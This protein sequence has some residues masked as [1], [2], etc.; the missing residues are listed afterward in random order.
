MTP[1]KEDAQTSEA[2]EIERAK[3]EDAEG[4]ILAL[5][6]ALAR[7]ERDNRL[8]SIASENAER[9]RRFHEAE[10]T[11]VKEQAE[12]AALSKSNFLAN[13]SHEI[14]TPMNAIKGLSELLMLTDLNGSQRNYVSNII[15]SSNSLLKI[16]NDVLDFSKI[17]AGRMEI[18]ESPYELTSLFT[19]LMSTMN[20][21]CREKELTLIA[22]VDPG[23][24]R[25]LKGDDVRVKQVLSN[26][27]SNAVKYTRKGCIILSLR[28]EREADGRDIR[29]VFSVRDTGIGIRP[30]DMDELFEAFS[31]ADLRKNRTII[32]TGLGLAI[33]KRLVQA[34][35]GDISLQSVYGEGS[36]FSFW[37][38][39]EVLDDTP[40]AQVR[41][42]R[43]LKVLVLG[44]G[45]RGDY[46]M[47]M[48]A[49]LSVPAV[50]CQDE[51][52]LEGALAGGITHCVYHE[53]EP[54][55]TALRNMRKTPENFRLVAVRDIR[56]VVEEGRGER[57]LVVFEPMLVTDLARA[58]DREANAGTGVTETEAARVRT[59][60]V[61]ALLVDDNE[62][63]LMVGAEILS[64]YGIETDSAASGMEAL[65]DS[66]RTKYDIIFMDQMMPEMDGIETTQKIRGQDGPNL[67]TPIVALTA[68]VM[69]DMRDVLIDSGMDDF[70]GKPIEIP[71]LNRVLRKWLPEE[72][73]LP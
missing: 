16:I 23:L 6:R 27:L 42:P 70:I 31:R 51:A 52:E 1:M 3:R 43:S 30:E 53:D 15:G 40:I 46:E 47:E 33:T 50:R 34:M 63:N 62:I 61:R 2:Y 5:E 64:S 41:E 60:G 9:L 56:N 69:H 22:D 66:S 73:Q 71:E 59:C 18:V 4:R 45:L 44:G 48:L 54:L 10:L 25:R 49:K 7:M 72:K 8:L 36:D 26:I 28:G 67:R 57:Q 13:M 35:G 58:L 39:Q 38:R 65:L 29:L 19:E 24:P 37:L 17:D 20:V 21:R 55:A 68:N 32:G 12:A 11:K 14:R